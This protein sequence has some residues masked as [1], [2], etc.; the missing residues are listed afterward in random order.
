MKEVSEG[1]ERFSDDRRIDPVDTT[2][3]R[4]DGRDQRPRAI[5]QHEHELERSV[6][7]HPRHHAQLLPRQRVS[8]PGD[9]HRRRKALEVG[10]VWCLPS[11]RYRTIV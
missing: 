11:T 3:I 1:T 6:A 7:V 10:S 4:P 5:G 8:L 9:P 2:E